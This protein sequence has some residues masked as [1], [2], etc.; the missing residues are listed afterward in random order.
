VTRTRELLL[1]DAVVVISAAVL[2]LCTSFA[3]AQQPTFQ[4]GGARNAFVQGVINTCVKT[5][6]A[7]ADQSVS[8]DQIAL[9]CKCYARAL[10]DVVNGQEYEARWIGSRVSAI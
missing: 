1:R 6:T 8:Q 5:Q 2:F 3:H 10:A 9:F 7:A 4:E